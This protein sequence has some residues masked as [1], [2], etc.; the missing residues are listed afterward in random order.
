MKY[1]LKK[2]GDWSYFYIPDLEEKGLLHGFFTAL[3]PVITQN[4]D[5]NNIFLDTFG[6][7][8]L[9]VL[10]QE[11]GDKVH[12]IKDGYK[13]RAGDGIIITEKNTAGVIKTAD[14]LPIVLFEPHYPMVAIIHAGWRGT[15]ERITEKALKEMI[16][17]GAKE[18]DVIVILGPSVNMCCYDVGE[19]VY[20]AF[21]LM[22]FSDLIFKRA[23]DKIFLSMR[24][25]NKEILFQHH[26]SVIYD[27]NICTY[28]SDGLFYSYRRGHREKRQINFVSLR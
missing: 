14:C 11:H 20:G 22:G 25:A 19:E 6:L 15:K 3:S 7:K 2:R 17:L 9:I 10:H 8:D 23:E 21:R 24:D 28:C 18:K 27:I 26:V 1:Q 4:N 5:H 16:G 12:V 13:P